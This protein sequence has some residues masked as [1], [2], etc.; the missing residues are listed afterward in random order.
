MLPHLADVMAPELWFMRRAINFA[1]LALFSTNDTVRY[2]SNMGIHN[3]NSIFGGNVR[4]LEYSYHM[5]GKNDLGK[6]KSV[7]EDEADIIRVVEQV[8]VV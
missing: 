7:C 3:S 8:K 6:W 4:F 1:K 5:N 2:I